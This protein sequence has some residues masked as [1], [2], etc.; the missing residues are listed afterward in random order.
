MF[1]PV[2]DTPG[3]GVPS[4]QKSQSTWRRVQFEHDGFF[5]SHYTE[6]AAAC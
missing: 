1:R 2:G 6:T 4:V 3:C 5:S